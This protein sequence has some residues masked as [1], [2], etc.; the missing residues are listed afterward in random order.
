[1]PLDSCIRLLCAEKYLV[2][3]DKVKGVY[4][5][6]SGRLYFFSVF[7]EVLKRTFNPSVEIGIIGG[8]SVNYSHEE[9]LEYL[10]E[11][12]R[13]IPCFQCISGMLELVDIKFGELVQ[14]NTCCPTCLS[15]NRFDLNL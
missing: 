7:A 10:K 5:F 12:I 15:E 11:E 6:M 2:N 8:G 1:M 9:L 13:T 3:K 14:V 4:S